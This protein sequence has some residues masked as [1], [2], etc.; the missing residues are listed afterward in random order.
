ML[1]LGR[2]VLK[3]LLISS[4]IGCDVSVW[5]VD[6]QKGELISSEDNEKPISC[7]SKEAVNFACV[8][9]ED[10]EKLKRKCNR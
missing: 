5:V 4:L 10:L 6:D 3:I 1:K 9:L 8:T 7:F 2:N